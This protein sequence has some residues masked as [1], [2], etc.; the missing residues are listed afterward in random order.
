MSI[1]A[2]KK[3]TVKLIDI[4]PDTHY[5]TQ[6]HDIDGAT[7]NKTHIPIGFIIYNTD[8]LYTMLKICEK[9]TTLKM[10]L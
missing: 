3:K 7:Y 1:D 2:E 5:P 6:F 4:I 8:T 10:C 9:K